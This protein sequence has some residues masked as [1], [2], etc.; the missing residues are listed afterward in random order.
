MTVCSVVD[1][2]GLALVL[3]HLDLEEFYIKS[4]EAFTFL[5]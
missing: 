4:A 1:I 3:K 5:E 2:K